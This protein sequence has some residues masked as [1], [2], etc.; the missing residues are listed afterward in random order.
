MRKYIYIVFLLVNSTLIYSQ[1]IS[2]IQQEYDKQHPN[3]YNIPI[4][5]INK[6]SDFC[7][8]YCPPNTN[9][10]ILEKSSA[11]SSSLFILRSALA[12]KIFYG[13]KGYKYAYSINGPDSKP[14]QLKILKKD[15]QWKV[16]N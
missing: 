10:W 11:L 6:G 1:S 5:K 12:K 14:I 16:E 7:F 8:Y 3:C 9:V 15:N 2:L 13:R 4:V